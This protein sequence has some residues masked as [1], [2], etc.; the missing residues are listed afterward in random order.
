MINLEKIELEKCQSPPSF[1][2]LRRLGLCT[3]LPPPFLIF[4]IPPPPREV[5]KIY[6]PCPFKKAVVQTICITIIL[7]KKNGRDKSISKCKVTEL[8]MI[9]KNEL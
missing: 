8:I 9:I 7:N 4:Q 6:L 3:I 5:I 1:P 2:L